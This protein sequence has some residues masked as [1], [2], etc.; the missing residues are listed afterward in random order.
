MSKF[1]NRLLALLPAL[2]LASAAFGAGLIPGGLSEF[3]VE[4]PLD[5]RKMA[6]RGQLSP[7]THVQVTI[8]APANIDMAH[9]WPVLVINATSVP[10][11]NSSRALLSAYAAVAIK[12]GWIVVAADPMQD[13]TVAQDDVAMRLALNTAALAVLDLQWPAAYQAPL[14]FGGF[15]AGAKYSSWLA[16]AFAS[17]G[18]NVAG[19]YLAGVNAETVIPAAEHFKVLN[20]N[21][22]R[23]PIYLQSG[24]KDDI[25]TPADHR[26]IYDELKRAGF[27]NVRLETFSGVHE[28]D[29]LPLR[30]ALEWFREF[31]VAPTPA[32]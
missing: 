15:S 11:F 3:K 29:P 21:F 18:R 13:I 22:K 19:I 1:M 2:M 20:A 10:Q 6:G 25:A 8:A 5:L 27:K 7:V 31:T 30:K 4:L 24:D 16:A 26:I 23:I 17:Q 14:A 28:I 32:K 12:A 9:D